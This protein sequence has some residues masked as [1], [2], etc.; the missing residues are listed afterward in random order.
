M[1]KYNPL[2]FYLRSC[3][4]RE[5]TLKVNDIE[6]I[7]GFDLPDTAYKRSAWWGNNANGHSQANSWLDSGYNTKDIKLGE[8]V[9]FIK[10]N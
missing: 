9:T 1:S 4:I 2:Q 7:L 8:S 6:E 3:E 10:V 5:V